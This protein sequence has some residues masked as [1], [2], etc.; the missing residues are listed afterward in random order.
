MGYILFLLVK[1]GETSDQIPDVSLWQGLGM[2][3]FSRGGPAGRTKPTSFVI[4]NRYA[5]PL[6]EKAR[7]FV[8]DPVNSWVQSPPVQD[9]M[10]WSG[11]FFSRHTLHRRFGLRPS[12]SVSIGRSPQNGG[13]VSPPASLQKAIVPVIYLLRTRSFVAATGAPQEPPNFLPFRPPASFIGGSFFAERHRPAFQ[14]AA[15]KEGVNGFCSTRKPPY[16]DERFPGQTNSGA[17][18]R[19]SQPG[20]SVSAW[21]L[22]G[23]I[24]EEKFRVGGVLC[25]L[26]LSSGAQLLIPVAVGQL[27]DCV[28][29]PPLQ[30]QQEEP[31]GLGQQPLQHEQQK[32]RET[33][34]Q[35][36]LQL[37]EQSMVVAAAD[38]T[39][40][41]AT[42]RTFSYNILH[43][44][45]R[46]RLQNPGA[47]VGLCVLLGVVGAATSFMRLYL[48]ESTV[49]QLDSPSA[50]FF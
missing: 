3:F 20:A 36:P 8:A 19:E 50:S 44:E 47:V 35:P 12:F 40:P 24:K 10:Y 26:L 34:Q 39:S 16:R 14:P 5:V 46:K 32:P 23:F 4:K 11:N 41:S 48:L 42:A 17:Q 9:C 45:G 25:A 38:S 33:K 1:P 6:K 49:R 21:E 28:A 22:L 13:G 7:L 29:Q 27:V 2:L 43:E 31:Q 15:K 37:G 18:Q 30:Q